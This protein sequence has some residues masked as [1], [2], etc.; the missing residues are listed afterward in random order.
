[1]I[2]RSNVAEFAY[3]HIVPYRRAVHACEG[4]GARLLVLKRGPNHDLPLWVKSA[5]KS[6]W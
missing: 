6:D 4:L 3:Y 5:S 1:M 2:I